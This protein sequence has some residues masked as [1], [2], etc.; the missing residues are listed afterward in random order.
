MR[1]CLVVCVLTWSCCVIS[2]AESKVP[3]VIAHWKLA[4]DA[5]DAGTHAL[6]GKNQGVQFEL[7]KPGPLHPVGVFGGRQESI[8][9]PH[10]PELKLGT[11][12]FSISL[13]VHTDKLLDDDL[14]DLLSKFD[15]VTRT[16]FHLTLRNNTGATNSLANWRQL[17]FGIDQHTEPVWT[18]AGRPG[19]SIF[20]FSMAVQDGALFVG[21]CEADPGRAGSV[22]R[23]AGPSKWIDLKLPNQ[24]NSVSSLAVFDGKLY[25][26]TAKYRLKGSALAESENPNLGGQI[27]RLDGADQWTPCG[28]FPEAEGIGGMTVYKGR[29]YASSLYKP[30]GFFR[31]EEDGKW[32]SLAPP[33]GKRTESM[34]V[35]N[36]YLWATSYDN[37]NIY[38]YDGETWADLGLTGDS[39]Q[40]YSF[41]EY[42]GQLYVGTWPSGKVYRLNSQDKWEDWGR[43]GMELEVMGMLNHNG[44]LYAGTLPLAEVYRLDGDREWARLR[45]L[46]PTDTKYRRVWTVAQFAGQAYWS[47][48]PTG[49]IFAM[50]T[51][52]C[53][54]YD[55]ELPAGWRHLAAVKSG[56]VLR[57]F[58]D[59]KRVAESTPF[60]PAALNLAND[61]PLRIGA[62]T[63]ANFKGQL[64]NLRLFGQS[65]TDADIAVLAAE[66]QSGD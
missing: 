21:T 16:G 3:P 44:K 66:Q 40:N 8:V 43:L 11:G 54:T 5:R 35:H 49:H 33:D 59:G 19:Q 45:Q 57:L 41:A 65:L 9:V 64:S 13:W 51:G 47:T 17:Q 30:A 46:D 36:G 27:F 58:V 60:D 42:Q 18:D 25:A 31:Y 55:R 20:G 2:S 28:H 32:T 37:G 39:T 48:L 23:Y 50:E 38:R 22:Y 1:L 63:G 56:G 10:A 14:G 15:P 34:G 29:L 52:K 62:G 7:A 53:V 12:D 26:G 6:H 4:G 61:Q 24:A